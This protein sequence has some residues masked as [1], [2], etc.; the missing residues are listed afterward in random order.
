MKTR[1]ARVENLKHQKAADGEANVHL[2]QK[3]ADG[4]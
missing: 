3:H 2:G 4:L 1:E